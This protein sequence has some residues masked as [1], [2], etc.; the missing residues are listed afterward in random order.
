MRDNTHRK[1]EE[2]KFLV[3]FLTFSPFLSLSL[4]VKMYMKSIIRSNIIP[5]QSPQKHT[6]TLVLTSRLTETD[7]CYFT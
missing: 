5:P 6:L 1:G 4:Y 3:F 7:F 2:K